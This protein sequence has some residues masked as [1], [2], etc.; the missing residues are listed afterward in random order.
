M[1]KIYY[2]ETQIRA[3]SGIYFASVYLKDAKDRKAIFDVFIK[4]LGIK[5]QS[6]VRP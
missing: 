3:L 5:S 4:V 2:T 1:F 6:N